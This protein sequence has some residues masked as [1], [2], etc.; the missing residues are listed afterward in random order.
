MAIILLDVV[1]VCCE[2]MLSAVCPKEPAL[3]TWNLGCATSS[4]VLLAREK[5]MHDYD[6]L[7]HWQRALSSIGLSLLSLLVLKELLL[8]F[9]VGFINFFSTG[10]HL[11]EFTVVITAFSLELYMF[12]HET[13]GAA[14]SITSSF[15]LAWRAL[16]LCHGF[17]ETLSGGILH[18]LFPHVGCVLY[19]FNFDYPALNRK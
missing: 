13:Q 14:V 17:I 19:V 1:A 2:T 4:S 7:E 15:L 3:S 8:I 10:P 5:L 18:F 16:R 12:V 11:I 6:L 9:A